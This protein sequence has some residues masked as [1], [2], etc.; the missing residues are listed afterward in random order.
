MNFKEKNEVPVATRGIGIYRRIPD[1]RSLPRGTWRRPDQEPRQ[2]PA[3]REAREHERALVAGE[4]SHPVR[5]PGSL[6]L[7][8][9]E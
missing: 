4:S 5:L 1:G 3:G 8:R 6:V 9:E 2:R 7:G